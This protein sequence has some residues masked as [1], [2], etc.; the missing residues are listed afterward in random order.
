MRR[1]V[2]VGSASPITSSLRSAAGRPRSP[3]TSVSIANWAG[4]SV[5]VVTAA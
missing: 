1:T 3:A 5:T 2:S 4:T